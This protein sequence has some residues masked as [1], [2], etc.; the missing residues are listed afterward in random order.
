MFRISKKLPQLC[1]RDRNVSRQK[2]GFVSLRDILTRFRRP[3]FSQLNVTRGDLDQLIR[4]A[5]GN[6]KMRFEWGHL[7]SGG[8]AIRTPQGH[9]RDVGVTSYYLP[10]APEPGL[11]AHGTTVANARSICET[12]L[13][14]SGRLHIHFGSMQGGRPVGVRPGSAA[15]VVA[16]GNACSQEGIEI[17]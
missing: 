9:S 17:R 13:R 2:D 5:W 10:I 8:V 4:G 11:L 12:G 1:R 14:R 15:I 3:E 7:E 16:D 6:R